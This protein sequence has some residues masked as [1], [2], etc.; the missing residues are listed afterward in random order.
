MM[1]GIYRGEEEKI[2]ASAMKKRKEKS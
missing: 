2:R 1:R